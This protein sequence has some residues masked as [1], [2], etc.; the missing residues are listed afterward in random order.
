MWRWGRSVR[1]CRQALSEARLICRDSRK[2]VL[3]QATPCETWARSVAR[4]TTQTVTRVTPSPL[5]IPACEIEFVQRML[6]LVIDSALEQ[7][8][9]DGGHKDVQVLA[10]EVGVSVVSH[11]PSCLYVE[12]MEG[13]ST[14]QSRRQKAEGG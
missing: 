12:R 9:D 7:A 8:I 5:C 14:R 10:G 11:V 13:K 4:M 2:R 1:R 6:N 3:K